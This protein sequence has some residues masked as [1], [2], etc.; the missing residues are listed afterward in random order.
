[1]KEL[2]IRKADDWHIHLRSGEM[3]KA[4]LPYTSQNFRR[5]I[6]MPNLIPPITSSRQAKDYRDRL[7]NNLPEKHIFEPYMTLYL[8]ESTR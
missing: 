1:M 7:L 3:L 6:I 8:T 4:V 5:G 2:I